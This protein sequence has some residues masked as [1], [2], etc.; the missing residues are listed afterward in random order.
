MALE[1]KDAGKMLRGAHSLKGTL[2]NLAARPASD[3]AA[4]IELAGR[5]E[6]WP[7]SKLALHSLDLEMVRVL[8]ALSALREEEIP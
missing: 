7:R 2:A 5:A 4:D 8:D 6:D 1:N 3:L